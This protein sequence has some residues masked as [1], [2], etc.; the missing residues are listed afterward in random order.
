MPGTAE[1]TYIGGGY[2]IPDE[3]VEQVRD[4]I[5]KLIGMV[6]AGIIDKVSA[7]QQLAVLV[8]VKE[9]WI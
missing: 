5:P 2:H 4:E 7:L 3:V 6:D 9:G 1:V 8:A